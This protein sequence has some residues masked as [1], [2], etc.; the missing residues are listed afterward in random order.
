MHEQDY[1]GQHAEIE[2]PLSK[3]VPADKIRIHSLAPT[4][5]I[6]CAVTRRPHGIIMPYLLSLLH[7]Y[8]NG[9]KDKYKKR[10]VFV[11]LGVGVAIQVAVVRLG[12]FTA[13]RQGGN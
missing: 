11:N 9:S 1:T 12:P 2:Q 8:N 7:R 13:M 3:H 6:G 5:R 10:Q 4:L